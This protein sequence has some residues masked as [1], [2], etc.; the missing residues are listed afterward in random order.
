[1]PETVTITNYVDR[2]VTETV[3][4]KFG[5]LHESANS[6]KH[7][8]TSLFVLI[9]TLLGIIALAIL[10]YTLYCAFTYINGI[11]QEKMRNQDRIRFS[12]NGL[13][14]RVQRKS[15]EEKLESARK[16]AAKV[17]AAEHPESAKID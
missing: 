11:V 14:L 8:L 15:R 17:W 4:V 10:G 9:I 3:T 2:V 5:A 16:L 7:G 13:D 12:E 1:M 6:V